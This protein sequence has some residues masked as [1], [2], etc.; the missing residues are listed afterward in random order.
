MKFTSYGAAEEVTWSKHLV[1]AG[2]TKIL[3]D[4]GMFQWK[5]NDSR[6]KNETFGFNPSEIDAV[7]LSHAHIDHCWLLPL[8]VKQ[9]FTGKIFCTP[10]TEDVLEIMLRDSAHVQKSDED[11]YKRHPEIHTPFKT[12]PLYDDQDVTKTMDLIHT[13][14]MHEKFNFK[15]FDVTFYE[16]GHVIWSVLIKLEANGSSL[17]FTGD[18]GRDHM[19]LL[20]DRENNIKTDVIV[21]ESTYGGRKHDPVTISSESMEKVILETIWKW[22]KVVIPSFA[23]E[24][25]QEILYYLEEAFK[26]WKIP[27]IPIYV[28]SPMAT[29]VTRVF[30]KHDEV[31][32]RDMKK[33]YWKKDKP[34]TLP[35][36]T[37]TET[38]EQSKRIAEEHIPSI[39]IA[40]SGMCEAGR[41]RHH[42]AKYIHKHTNTIMFVWYMAEWTLGRKLIEH[43][44]QVKILG[45]DYRVR[46]N[47]V[48]LNS[49]SW[50]ADED[51]LL[52]WEEWISGTKKIILVHWEKNC[53]LALKEKLEAKW[54]L[55]EIAKAKETIVI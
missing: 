29:R 10:A 12:E 11:F 24:R 39:I 34:F 1:Q 21:M 18:I 35:N 23:L 28:D 3:L 22:W 50:H 26:S 48:K 38:V 49:F 16:A 46:A 51:E 15:D 54:R 32:D 47:I 14:S 4:C 30:Q 52:S 53:Q 42:L 13:R 17:L 5:R 19:P 45:A 6:T 20:K 8:L 33:H 25:T 37:F 41:V 2:N 9:G 40:G 43:I 7:M 31:Y 44:K 36:I 55:V 27:D